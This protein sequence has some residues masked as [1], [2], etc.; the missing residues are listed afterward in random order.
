M[1]LLSLRMNRKAISDDMKKYLFLIAGL[2]LMTACG[3]E[4]SEAPVNDL[5]ASAVSFSVTPV[6][7]L[8]RANGEIS[9]VGGVNA[10]PLTSFGVFASYTGMR[11]YESATVT[12]NFMYNQKVDKTASSWEYTPMKYW[13]NT[14][15]EYTSFFAYAP[16]EPSPGKGKCIEDMSLPTEQGDPW[17]IYR[18]AADPWSDDNPQVDLLYGQYKTPEGSYTAMTDRTKPV[19]L[20]ERM[21]FSFLH[22]LACYGENVKVKRSAELIT[23]LNGQKTITINKVTLKYYNLTTKAKLVLNATGSANWKEVISGELLATRTLTKELTAG[24]VFSNTDNSAETT[25]TVAENAGLFYIPLTIQGQPTA[26]VQITVV[27]TVTDATTGA[28]TQLEA[29]GVN[30]LPMDIEAGKSDLTIT[31]GKDLKLTRGSLPVNPTDPADANGSLPVNPTN[32]TDE[33]LAKQH[34]RL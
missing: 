12:P 24:N 29:T 7:T 28:A 34:N 2:V 3:N 21:P 19:V 17:I 25:V 30:D 13:P 27:Y 1:H 20:N 11:K 14:A 4:L 32:S 33:N 18:L 8:T 26:K 10:M 22:A 31:L 23:K 9:S 6:E 16:Y 15:D 5:P